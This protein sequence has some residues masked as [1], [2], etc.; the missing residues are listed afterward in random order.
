MSKIKTYKLFESYDDV[1]SIIKDVMDD[2]EDDFG[3]DCLYHHGGFGWSYPC[4][5]ALVVPLQG[6]II[7]DEERYWIEKAIPSKSVGLEK[8]KKKYNLIFQR[9]NNNTYL[10]NQG[11]EI[12]GMMVYFRHNFVTFSN[13]KF[14][15]WDDFSEDVNYGH[16][17]RMVKKIPNL[18]EVDNLVLLFKMS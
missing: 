8:I 16:Y 2:I 5:V 15:S 14:I 6:G 11:I 12:V 17:M 4:D 7:H 3:V 18:E 13:K 9:L 1:K 10:T